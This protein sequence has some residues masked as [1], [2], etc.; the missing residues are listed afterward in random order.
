MTQENTAFDFTAL[1]AAIEAEVGQAL[2]MNEVE[3]GGGGNRVILESGSYLGAMVEYVDL[4]EQ[5]DIYQG[6]SKGFYPKVRLGFAVFGFKEQADGSF[7]MDTEN[8]VIL[9]ESFFL[10]RHEKAGAYK[11]FQGLNIAND[12]NIKHFAQFFMKPFMLKV[13][14]RQNKDKTRYYNVVDLTGTAPAVDAMTRQP[15]PLPDIDDKF[16]VVFLWNNPNKAM[17]DKLYIDGTR[18]DGSSKNFIQDEIA[19]AANF[20]GSAVQLLIGGGAKPLPVPTPTAT[21]PAAPTPQPQAAAQPQVAAP[22]PTPQPVG[23]TAPA[24]PTM[25]TMPYNADMDDSNP[26]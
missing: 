4:G 7:A 17:W 24:M 23:A 16:K 26:F 8:P 19:N 2:D 3:T 14:K 6:A 13:V 15:Y 10:K 11:A 5:E 12:P 20:H 22:V 18:D 25:P 21:A 1:N 9:R